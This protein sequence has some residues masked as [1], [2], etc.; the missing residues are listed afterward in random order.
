MNTG[1][2]A[3][4][5]PFSVNTGFC[6]KSECG[7]EILPKLCQPRLFCPKDNS[8]KH[9][10][11][12]ATISCSRRVRKAL[13]MPEV[14]VTGCS[15]ISLLLL[16]HVQRLLFFLSL[17]LSLFPSLTSN[18]NSAHVCSDR[19]GQLSVVSGDVVVGLVPV[20]LHLLVH[21]LP[22]VRANS[23]C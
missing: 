18:L 2:W 23:S 7:R 14:E 4:N 13:G 5:L 21:L 12:A 20:L 8:C 1:R 17:F 3:P 22:F 10:I 16:S 6:Q 15:L 9:S 11:H 19:G